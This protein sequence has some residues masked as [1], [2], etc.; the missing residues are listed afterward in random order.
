[1][2]TQHGTHSDLHSEQGALSGGPGAREEGSAVTT[3]APGRALTLN[4][5]AS[6]AARS[7][8]AVSPG[9]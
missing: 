1:M 5:P 6:G 8:G 7:R 2:T 9:F 3:A 4:T